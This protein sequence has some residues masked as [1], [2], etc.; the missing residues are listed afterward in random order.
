MTSNTTVSLFH[1][2]SALT[3]ENLSK[4]MNHHKLNIYNA[5]YHGGNP[6]SMSNTRYGTN[7]TNGAHYSHVISNFN[8]EEASDLQTTGSSSNN[9]STQSSRLQSY[10][11]PH[12]LH[13]QQQQQS[14][15]QQQHLQQQQQQLLHNQQNH[16]QQLSS[17]VNRIRPEK[18]NR[19]NVQKLT[20]RSSQ[21][22]KGFDGE[23][24][25]EDYES[26]QQQQQQHMDNSMTISDVSTT[27]AI[28]RILLLYENLQFREAAN[29][30]NR[31]NYGTF[32]SIL[33]DLPI[34]VFV[35]SIP[36]SL[37]ILEALYAKVFLSCGDGLTVS[38][39]F[40]HPHH[41]IMQMVR[42][43][44]LQNP[45]IPD[46]IVSCKKLLKVII[47]SEPGL[48]KHV[49]CKKRS[50][51]RAIEGMGHHGLVGTSDEKLMVL[52]EAL[53]LEFERVIQQYKTAVQKLEELA[54]AK[55]KEPTT[56]SLSQGPAPTN[57]SH[58]RLLSLRQDEIQERLIKNKTLLNAIEPC[59]FTNHSL[60]IL[61]AILQ[62]RID[63]D[64]EVLFQFTQ[65]R[66]EYSA[67]SPNSTAQNPIDKEAIVAPVLMRF[68][69]GCGQ[70]LNLIKEVHGS[71]PM[72][73]ND[74][75]SDISGYH[76]DS[77]SALIMNSPL[78]IPNYKAT[79][80]YNTVLYRSVRVKNNRPS[81]RRLGNVG[82]SSSAGSDT[83]SFSDSGKSDNSNNGGNNGSADVKFTSDSISSGSRRDS[84]GGVGGGGSGAVTVK[85][86]IW[87][88]H[89]VN[90][91]TE[92]DVLRRELV[93]AKQ[94]IFELQDKER[95]M[96]DRLAEQT[97]RMLE[98][99]VRF[100]NVCL[101]DRRP[102]ALIRK[103]GN[104]YAQARVDTLDAL[105]SLQALKDADELKSK[106][107]FSVVVLAFRSVHH[108]LVDIRRR[109]NQLLQIPDSLGV[110]NIDPSVKELHSSVNHYLRSNTDRFD[111]NK[112][113]EEVCTQIWATLY[114]YPCLKAC[115]L[116]VTYVRDCVRLAWALSIQTPSYVIEYETRSF[117][118]DMHIK[119]HASNQESDVIKTYL[120]PAL[121]EEAPNCSCVHKGVV[122]T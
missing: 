14:M 106:L 5:R 66:K 102:T 114:D 121:L 41:V 47:L 25:D 112:N 90:D 29:F 65:L 34:D 76:S 15:Q 111:V 120:W 32:R 115:D 35:E 67:L 116:L 77:D 68:S 45:S 118:K 20:W 43:F 107:L 72:D 27:V 84:S 103:Y 82:E 42:L 31:L 56:R 98:R 3:I 105:D 51:D 80:K 6:A 92:V 108:L 4:G 83:Q 11:P 39:N 52:H 40:L 9:H 62:K 91:T 109:L 22:V 85:G 10:P 55:N 30:I 88:Q 79:K 94:T 75:S 24:G 100:E 48:R 93:K 58:Q 44:A 49:Y 7:N 87:T 17:V 50:L 21:W 69:H 110:H 13:L 57:S 18:S 63:Y 1:N 60:Q 71:D 64:K 99:G 2:P 12:S 89:V 19:R 117:R 70:V 119:F 78:N 61:L 36:N 122:I 16:S 33:T 104:L 8:T 73:N 101:G 81:A 113:V 96:K 23:D 26:S 86:N 95:K 74:D 59:S 54:L 53:K 28:R 46:N 38:F 97:Q 37:P